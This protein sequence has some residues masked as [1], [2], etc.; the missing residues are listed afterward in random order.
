MDYPLSVFQI[1]NTF[2]VTS[3]TEKQ[4]IFFH[5]VEYPPLAQSMHPCYTTVARKA[6]NNVHVRF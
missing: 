1:V 4:N 3:R 6:A 5:S 2:N